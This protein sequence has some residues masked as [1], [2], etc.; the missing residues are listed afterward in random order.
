MLLVYVCVCFIH[1]HNSVHVRS[2]FTL[3]HSGLLLWRRVLCTVILLSRN[4]PATH[5]KDPTVWCTRIRSWLNFDLC[6]TWEN[7]SKPRLLTLKP[8]GVP[9]REALLL[10]STETVVTFIF[11]TSVLI[12]LSHPLTCFSGHLPKI[13]T[14]S[15]VD[16]R[17]R[18]RMR[19]KGQVHAG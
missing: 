12:R 1:L 11:I 3:S 8:A 2:S 17:Q 18:Y 16:M 13:R 5:Y 15:K 19:S 6:L 9:E 10:D 7:D 4:H 14:F